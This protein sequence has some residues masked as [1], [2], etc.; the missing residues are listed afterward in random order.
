MFGNC[1]DAALRLLDSLLCESS[2]GAGRV[3][4]REDLP[5]TQLLLVMSG[6][7]HISRRG[8]VFGLA[9]RGA[10]VGGRELRGRTRYGV[11]MTAETPMRLRAATARGLA[12]ML[13]LV[14]T[15]EDAL[16]GN[17]CDD[18][19][20]AD[21]V[22]AYLQARTESPERVVAALVF[23][24]MVRSRRAVSVRG[25]R[26]CRGSFEV[27]RRIVTRQV[28]RYNGTVAIITR[29]GVL[30][31]FSCAY[32]AARCARAIRTELRGLGLDVQV[33][34]LTGAIEPPETE[35]AGVS[36]HIVN[37]LAVA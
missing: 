26:S 9:Q 11:T 31:R 20:V 19:G 4:I 23:T 15:L 36:M 13:A 30:A 2:A 29:D 18:S 28:V 21:E 10:L 8:E 24:D 22:E 27:F 16:W 14:P 5:A 32:S 17:S 12:S 35:L 1:D 6:R 3:L 37:R 33:G 25:D 34:P 7:A